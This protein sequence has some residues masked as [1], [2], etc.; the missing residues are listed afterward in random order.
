MEVSRAT[1]VVKYTPL[2]PLLPPPPPPP[3][4]VIP[5]SSTPVL[6]G[7]SVGGLSVRWS[8]QQLQ[9]PVIPGWSES[10]AAA[11]RR[12]P[13][14][15]PA[16]PAAIGARQR[17]HRVSSEVT[18]HQWTPADRQGASGRQRRWPAAPA[19]RSA[20]PA[21]RDTRCQVGVPCR[22]VCPADS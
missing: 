8:A 22:H 12:T 13:V 15:P 4:R 2:L 14:P 9:P 5:A 17:R 16:A 6:V 3:L 11:Q 18:G 1:L 7:R 10:L 19:G 21:R 20:W